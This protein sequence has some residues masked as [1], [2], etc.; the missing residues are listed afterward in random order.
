MVRGGEV[1]NPATAAPKVQRVRTFL[2]LQGRDRRILA[3][4]LQTVGSKGY[5]GF[6]I[7]VVE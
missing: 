6:S 5:D 2:E 4:A 1:S 3:I 7:A